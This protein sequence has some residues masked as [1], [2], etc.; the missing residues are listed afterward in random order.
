MNIHSKGI[1]IH[2]GNKKTTKSFS[3]KKEAKYNSFICE[4][5][6]KENATQS[7]L[8]GDSYVCRQIRMMKRKMCKGIPYCIRQICNS[9]EYRL[10]PTPNTNSALKGSH[11]VTLLDEETYAA[12][13]I[14]KT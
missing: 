7:Q 11:C 10:P 6:W 12:R 9:K 8:T 1:K 3:G 13:F 14:K 2:F 4:G 5:K